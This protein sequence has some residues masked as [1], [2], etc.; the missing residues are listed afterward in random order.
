MLDLELLSGGHCHHPECI[1]LQGGRWRA[2]RF[3]SLFAVIRHP[4]RGV[5]LYDTGYAPHLLN[6]RHGWTGRVYLWVTPVTLPP[7]QTAL[8]QLGERGIGPEDVR[9]IVISHFH[10]DHIAGLRDFP[11]ARLWCSLS[12]YQEVA[13]KVGLAALRRGFL[14]GL[15]PE[16][17]TARCQPI[18]DARR[19]ALPPEYSP[20]TV[21][22]DL[23]GDGSALAVLLPG[24][25]AGQL[26]LLLA[27][28]TGRRVFLIGDAC[29]SET[30]YLECRPPHP[31]T[32]LITH[33][34]RDYLA[35][36]TSL[37]RLAL[38]QPELLLIPSHSRRDYRGL[39]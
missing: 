33:S 9:D 3:P 30:A 38:R 10:A 24:H 39:L 19:V 25:A 20:F 13:G 2:T 35:T 31:I 26:G 14:P 27:S 5:M 32:R 36:L 6:G 18:E 29:W 17:F 37:H 28:R 22:H 7:G 4:A 8:A 21:A 11:R 15:L 16:D 23:F 12:A 1:T 34:S